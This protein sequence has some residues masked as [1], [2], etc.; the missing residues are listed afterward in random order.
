MRGFGVMAIVVARVLALWRE[1]LGVGG[2]RGFAV[3]VQGF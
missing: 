1:D 3:R 2:L